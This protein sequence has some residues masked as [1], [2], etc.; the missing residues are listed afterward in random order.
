MVDCLATQPESIQ[1]TLLALEQLE[2]EGVVE[3]VLV[4]N[5][6]LWRKAQ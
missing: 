5:L 2:A 6:F 4:G 1:I 3:R